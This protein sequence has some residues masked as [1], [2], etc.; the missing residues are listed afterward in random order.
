VCVAGSSPGR[1]RMGAECRTLAASN[2]N[3]HGDVTPGAPVSEPQ[4]IGTGSIGMTSGLD[5]HQVP[6]RLCSRGTRGSG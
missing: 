1:P 5:N 2:A 6:V 4:R 3:S